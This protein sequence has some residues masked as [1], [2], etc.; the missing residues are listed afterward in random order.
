[1]PRQ[2]LTTLTTQQRRDLVTLILQFV[3]NHHELLAHNHNMQLHFTRGSEFFAWHRRL[4][5]AMDEW[6]ARE[7]E[8]PPVTPTHTIAADSAAARSARA[9]YS[10]RLSGERVRE[11]AQPRKVRFERLPAWIPWTAPPAEFV[12]DP[13]HHTAEQLG[14]INADPLIPSEDGGGPITRGHFNT[15]HR[16]DIHYWKQPGRGLDCMGIKL[17]W[18]IAGPLAGLGIAKKGPHFLV[19]LA[20]GGKVADIPK[21]PEAPLFWPWHAFIDDIYQSWLDIG[22]DPAPKYGGPWTDGLDCI[23]PNVVGRA[24]HGHG[25]VQGARE[26]I[27]YHGLNVGLEWRFPSEHALVV[28]Q[29]P[30]PGTQLEIGE[31]VDLSA[32]T[33]FPDGVVPVCVGLPLKAARDLIENHGLRV[34]TTHGK[35]RWGRRVGF[36]N[37]LQPVAKQRPNPGSERARDSPVDLLPAPGLR[38]P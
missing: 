6:V 17:E 38:W 4:I 10:S 20:V 16:D 9:R 24:L 5:N 15:F 1:M 7:H 34:G 29:R 31:H 13:P 27:M 30:A 21:A 37:D 12:D 18:G 11:P 36:A 2:D 33:S 8:L 32:A 26:L 14:G 22:G 28:K 35:N 3:E 19:H 23:V 25:P